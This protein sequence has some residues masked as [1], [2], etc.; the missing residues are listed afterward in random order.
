MNVIFLN[1]NLL[2][3]KQISLNSVHSLSEGSQMDPINSIIE[4][5]DNA[6]DAGASKISIEYD[7]KTRTL[8]ISSIEDEKHTLTDWEDLFN[9]GSRGAPKTKAG[10]IGKFNQGFKYACSCLVG[11]NNYGSVIVVS[12]PLGCARWK[13]DYSDDVRYEDLEY[14]VTDKLPDG[15]GEYNFIVRIEGCVSIDMKAQKELKQKLG[16][17]YRQ[18]IDDGS[19]EFYLFN[20]IIDSIDVLYSHLGDRVGYKKVENL[21]WRSNPN[22]AIFESVDLRMGDLKEEEYLAYDYG[23]SKRRGVNCSSRSGV[24]IVYN[25]VTLIETGD[26]SVIKGLIG[27]DAQPSTSG[28]RARLTIRDKDMFDTYISTGGNKCKNKIN[29]LFKD[30]EETKK[31][32]DVI[33]N[34]YNDVLVKYH[35]EA[36]KSIRETHIDGLDEWLKKEGITIRFSFYQGEADAYAFSK[37]IQEE[38]TI[39][40][41]TKNKLFAS[42]HQGEI[43]RASFIMAFM[44]SMPNSSLDEVLNELNIIEVETRFYFKNKKKQ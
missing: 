41:N 6:I 19:C 15:I 32:R 42:Y 25:G 28:Y 37:S 35:Q 2:S 30:D 33:R 24:E 7:E 27:I 1:K 5:T 26:S 21:G 44:R 36:S 17:R 39:R 23:D 31:I 34:S 10:G 12:K 3:K 11:G 40:V 38:N 18:I 16:I 13:I 29:D 4:L 14:Q 22:A 9:L 43:G 20:G 8:T